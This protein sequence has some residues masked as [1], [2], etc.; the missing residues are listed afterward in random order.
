MASI[1]LRQLIDNIL[2]DTSRDMREQ[3]DTVDVCFQK[4][5]EEME[6]SKSKMEENLRKVRNMHLALS[7]CFSW[8][9]CYIS[10]HTWSF[11]QCLYKYCWNNNFF[12]RVFLDLWWNCTNG[13]EHWYAEEGYTW[14][15]EP[16]ESVPDSPQQPHVQTRR[17]ALSR[18]CAIQ[19][20]LWYQDFHF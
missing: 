4:R 19:V 20:R 8:M 17:R 5:L 10:H 2:A 11:Q 16:N 3:C 9:K 6:D 7:A 13:E 12:T 1:Q 15:R 18:S 14:Q